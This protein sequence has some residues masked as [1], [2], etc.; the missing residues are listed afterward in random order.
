MELQDTLDKISQLQRTEGQLYR[1]LTQN[2]ENVALGKSNTFTAT[3]IQDITAQIN[4][5]SS[6]RVNLYNSLS[7]TYH[8]EASNEK[9]A[10][11]ALEQQTKTLRLLEEELNK[12]K[13]KLSTLKNEKTN[14]LKM[15]EIT[16][17]Y[18]KQYDAYRRLMRL[19]TI[20]GVCMLIAIGLQYTP[21]KFLS[22]P[23]VSIIFLVGGVLLAWRVINMVLRRKDNYDEYDWP[24]A[25]TSGSKSSKY[26]VGI[27]G[28]PYV[29]AQSDC[30]NE[31]TVWSDKG[32]IVQ[33]AVVQTAG[34]QPAAVQPVQP[35]TK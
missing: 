19:F 10:Q 20:I 30:C 33:P 34:L 18:S 9:N 1:A 26:A 4:S 31:G 25:P 21:L 23:L 3:E 13:K 15:I 6:A 14:Q 28:L 11:D 5:L 22:A 7:E 2:A 32:C 8:N 12:S 17:Y 27:T 24:G 29:C 35:T 16:T